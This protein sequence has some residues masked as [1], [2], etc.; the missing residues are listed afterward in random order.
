[1]ANNDRVYLAY[2][3]ELG[4]IFETETKRRID[5]ILEQAGEKESILDIGCSQGIVSILLAEKGKHVVGL[6]I[7]PEAI[8]FAQK[9]L[10]EKYSNVKERVSFSCVDFMEYESDSKFDCIVITEVLEHLQNPDKFLKKAS[11]LLDKDGKMIISV[12][13]GVMDHPDHVSTFYLSNFYDLINQSTLI[14]SIKF[15]ERWMGAVAYAKENTEIEYII[16]RESMK[17]QE[18]NFE[19]IDRKMNLRI[20]ELYTKLL[21]ANK[22]YKQSTERYATIKDMLEEHKK[23]YAAIKAVLKEYE[24]N[25][26]SKAMLLEEY[27]KEYEDI[28][29]VLKEY[30]KLLSSSALYEEKYKNLLI[31]DYKDLTTTTNIINEVN[32]KLQRLSNQN[33]ELAESNEQYR[34]RLEMIENNII[35]KLEI[36]IYRKLK[37]I[38]NKIFRS[39]PVK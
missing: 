31:E 28:K 37:A 16:D 30:E 21:E 17:E 3:G 12:P 19:V 33:K 26:S 5:W 27:K 13:F 39:I 2:S 14:N 6:D 22:K 4:E 36:R 9:L 11:S 23:E 25:D 8:E 29:A 1:M 34:S 38:K 32:R 24:E 18:R 35:W 10:E 7:Q 20:N 15:M